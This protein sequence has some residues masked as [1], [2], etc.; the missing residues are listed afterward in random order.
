MTAIPDTRSICLPTRAQRR[1][2]FSGFSNM[3]SSSCLILPL[4]RYWVFC[5]LLHDFLNV[6]HQEDRKALL[7]LEDISAQDDPENL[8]DLADYLNR[9][10]IPFQV[11]LIPIY[12]D[13]ANNEEI[14]LS[15]R[16]AFVRA[17]RYM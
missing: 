2:R 13:P 17:I 8:R 12:R 15:D 1:C 14:Y 3:L 9:R 5:D 16:P 10:G 11:S 7:R 6:P 4:R